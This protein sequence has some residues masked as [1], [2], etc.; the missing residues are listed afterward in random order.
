MY[1]SSRIRHF[2]RNNFLLVSNRLS[3]MSFPLIGLSMAVRRLQRRIGR[4]KGMNGNEREK[5]I[6]RARD[7]FAPKAGSFLEETQRSS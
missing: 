7:I 6:D 5:E 2:L 1:C 4:M 3:I